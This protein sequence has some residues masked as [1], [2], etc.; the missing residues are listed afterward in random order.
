MEGSISSFW[1]PLQYPVNA[2]P[3]EIHARFD[4]SKTP[5]GVV[6]LC[7]SGKLSYPVIKAVSIVSLSLDQ[8][9]IFA[10][11]RDDNDNDND[12]ATAAFDEAEN[13][14]NGA[15]CIRL[16]MI[17]PLL[18]ILEKTLL[19]AIFSYCYFHGHDP[20]TWHTADSAVQVFCLRVLEKPLP[21]EEENLQPMLWEAMM[22]RAVYGDQ[23]PA[24]EYADHM[25][26]YVEKADPSLVASRYE[27]AR[28]FFWDERL[29]VYL[30]RF[31]FSPIP[32][33]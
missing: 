1:G 25:M 23:T 28:R 18:P 8:H 3:A 27:V 31:R 20:G 32:P 12:N 24:R 16:F 17:F 5:L 22:L 15:L 10:P 2:T 30:K 13:R 26:R 6:S 14:I 9:H 7:L 33:N 21:T 19:M 4:L 11:T 29:E